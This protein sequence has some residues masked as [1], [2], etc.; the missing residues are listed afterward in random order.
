MKKILAILVLSLFIFNLNT[1]SAYTEK[2]KLSADF[3]SYKDIIN[4]Q[5]NWEWYKLD[6]EITR[7]EMAKVTLNL[8]GVLVRNQCSGKFSDLKSWDWGCKYVEAWLSNSFFAQNNNFN[9]DNNISKIE[10][11][12][13]VMKGRKIEKEITDD[14]R[15]GYVNSALKAGLLEEKFYDYDTRA[16]RWWIFVMAKQAI[17]YSWDD[18]DIKLIEELLNL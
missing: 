13:M 9:P 12:K 7:R 18:E 2:E 4:T 15:E 6:K 11:L 5:E 16:T 1:V 8:S 10:A 14:W 17:E 3:L